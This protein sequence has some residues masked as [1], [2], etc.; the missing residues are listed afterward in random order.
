MRN[1]ISG[2]LVLILGIAVQACVTGANVNVK[3]NSYEIAGRVSDDN[4]VPTIDAASR[5]YVD[6][7][8]AETRRKCIEDPHCLNYGGYGSDLDLYG[9]GS[10]A[11]P[12]SESQEHA[13]E[14]VDQRARRMAR[15]S[16]KMHKK[17][18]EY[19]ESE[20]E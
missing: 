19:H 15:D 8:E 12:A 11:P 13:G 3:P 14:A 6:A 10:I 2:V 1:S 17:H 7:Y 5:A 20:D 9:F 18:K 16:L 4:V